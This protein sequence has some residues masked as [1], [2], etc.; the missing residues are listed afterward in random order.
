LPFDEAGIPQTQVVEDDAAH[1]AT[2]DRAV[3]VAEDILHERV[4][5]DR[6]CGDVVEVVRREARIAMAPEVGRDHFEARGRERRD[7][8][9]P[10]ALGL[11]I[12]VQE[13]QRRAPDALAHVCDGH[14]VADLGAMRLE[15]IRV[16]AV[17]HGLVV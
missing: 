17:G 16:G 6:E 3:L 7:V 14:A 2:S 12:A 8:A 5:V 10:D 1:V 4:A 15:E 9:P 11:R 13:E